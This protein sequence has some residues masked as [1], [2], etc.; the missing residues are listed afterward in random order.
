MHL[1]L[2]DDE[3]DLL[4]NTAE[5]GDA[6]FAGDLRRTAEAERVRVRVFRSFRE[7]EQERERR[8]RQGEEE[9]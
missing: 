9:S 3:A 5:L 8:V 6:W 2:A 7:R 4:D 1:E